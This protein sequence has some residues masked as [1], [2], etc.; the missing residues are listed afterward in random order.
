MSRST[1]KTAKKTPPA[2]RRAAQPSAFLA[3]RAADSRL[4]AQIR[5]QLGKHYRAKYGVK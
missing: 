2:S 4:R 3:K 5:K 1:T